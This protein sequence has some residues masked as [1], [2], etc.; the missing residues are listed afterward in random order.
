MDY[1]H[2]LGIDMSKEWLDASILNCKNPR[3]TKHSQFKNT[4]KGFIQLLEWLR[5]QGIE[6]FSK[7]FV[8]MEHTGV[9]TI[10]LCEFLSDNQMVY[11][12]IPGAEISNSLGIVRSKNDQTDSK[13]IAR[14]AYKNREEIR[15][16]TLPSEPIRTL[17]ALLSYRERLLKARHGFKVSSKEI[18][19]FETDS[20]ASLM[21]T[22][23]DLMI[24]MCSTQMK[25]IEKDIDHL[26]AV[27]PEL[28][29]HY[30]LLLSV[31][32]IG[33]QNALYFIVYTQNFVRFTNSKQF[34]SY[35]GIAPFSQSSG[36]SKKS[37]SKVSHKANKKMKTLLTSAVV[38]S[39]S[40]CPEYRLYFERQRKRGK[41]ENS[42][43]NA[44][45][46]K[47]TSRVFAVIKRGSPYVNTHKFAS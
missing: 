42:I 32:G 15:I 23:S 38:C 41:N 44:I 43:K 16:H 9:Y 3:V 17:K 2:Y 28:Q 27:H 45:R 21:G 12:L 36:K 34:A 18:G 8:C 31:P 19:A 13:R 7:V 25:Q 10:P 40:T 33:R 47:I 24:E 14:Y 20:I 11:T 5:L 22:R 29:K 46:N 39:W 35:S 4:I 6:N 1:S 37:K 30:E 26:I